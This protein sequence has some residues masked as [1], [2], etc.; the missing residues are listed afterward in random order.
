MKIVKMLVF[1]LYV[2]T[3]ALHGVPGVEKEER[4]Y[5]LRIN[6]ASFIHNGTNQVP[7]GKIKVLEFAGSKSS[8]KTMD[9]FIIN[10]IEIEKKVAIH[11]AQEA[12][13]LENQVNQK[14]AA[15]LTEIDT[16]QLNGLNLEELD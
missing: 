10:W 12:E 5:A 13:E 1:G 8:Y 6:P 4:K 15:I 3:S 11:L 14:F 9:Q 7:K 16:S 2:L